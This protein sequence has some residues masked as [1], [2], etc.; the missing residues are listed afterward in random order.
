MSKTTWSSY[1]D[2]TAGGALNNAIA[3]RIG[4]DPA[5][6]GRWR[7][8]AVDPKPRQVVAYARAFGLSPI[9]ALIAAGYITHEE[10]DLPTGPPRA[11]SLDDFTTLELAEELTERVALYDEGRAPAPGDNIA[12]LF[13]G[14]G[15]VANDSIDEDRDEHDADFD[16]A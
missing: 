14:L 5:T 11:Y 12:P 8:G 15:L 16:N 6:I 10:V 7:T 2:A 4:V 1:I 3:D 9:Q 13:S